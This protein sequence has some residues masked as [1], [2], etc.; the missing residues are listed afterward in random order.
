MAPANSKVIEHSA[1]VCPCGYGQAGD[2]GFRSKDDAKKWDG[3]TLVTH[4]S[5]DEPVCPNA[6]NHAYL[7]A[8]PAAGADAARLLALETEMAAL[9]AKLAEPAPVPGAAPSLI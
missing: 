5:G 8:G 2:N 7:T 6:G 4:F 1:F 3:Q 9:R